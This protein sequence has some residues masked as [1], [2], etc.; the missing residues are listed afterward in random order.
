MR[1]P[2]GRDVKDALYE[3]F[4]RIG[5]AVA[6]PKRV[7]LL[8][9]LCQGE[10]M[11]EALARAT[12]MG[13]TNT[14]AHL[15]ALRSARLV[16]VRKEGTKAFYRLADPEVCRFFFSLRDLAR[17]RLAEV[18]QVVRDFFEARDEL[19]PVRRKDLLGR[20]RRE[21]VVVV[22]VRPPEEYRAGHIPGALSVPLP[23]LR[24]RLPELP[25]DVEVVAY[26][27][28]PYC[29]MAPEALR[30]LREG[31]FRARRLEDGFPE[32]RLARLPVTAGEERER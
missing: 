23:Q 4:A 26:C 31:G 14:S 19:E 11:V 21:E 17:G 10:R 6:S 20:L 24:S 1:Q 15:Q 32:W 28:G 27:R 16:E 9:L 12:E 29:V 22:D 8:D 3:Q 2:T 30:I 5:K 25:K 13:I 18:E 7:E